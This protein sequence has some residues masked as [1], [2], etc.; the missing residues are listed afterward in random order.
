MF[1]KDATH[2]SIPINTHMIVTLYGVLF[3]LIARRALWYVMPFYRGSGLFPDCPRLCFGAVQNIDEECYLRNKQM[4][5]FETANC[6]NG[7]CKSVNDLFFFVN[8]G[9]SDVKGGDQKHIA[10]LGIC[11]AGRK[12]LEQLSNSW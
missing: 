12:T 8:A 4:K 10:S 9:L 6:T 11:S 7:M 3:W 5:T 2:N 1:C